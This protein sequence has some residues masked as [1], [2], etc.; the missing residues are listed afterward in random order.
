MNTIKTYKQYPKYLYYSNSF[1]MGTTM[2]F[3]LFP[4]YPTDFIDAYFSYDDSNEKDLFELFSD[5]QMV[6][7]DIKRSKKI[8]EQ[9]TAYGK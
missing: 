1:L 6:G 8:F 4:S 9:E 3:N 2:S 5:W 7:E